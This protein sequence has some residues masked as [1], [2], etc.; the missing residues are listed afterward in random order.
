M[1]KAK[2]RTDKDTVTQDPLYRD[3]TRQLRELIT[4]GRFRA[5]QRFLSEREVQA[6]FQVS[7]PTANKA[8][9]SLMADGFVE[10]RRGVGTFVQPGV[11]DYDLRKLVSFTSK[12]SAAGL[13]PTTRVLQFRHLSGSDAVQAAEALMVAHDQPLLYMERLRLADDRPVILERRWV[14]ADLCPRLSAKDVA[15]SVYNLWTGR[16]GLEIAEARQTLRAVQLLRDDAEL[17]EVASRSAAM[18]CRCLG[19]LADGRALWWEHTLYRADAYEFHMRLGAAGAPPPVAG[20]FR[21]D[22][23]A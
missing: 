19:A 7:R 6:R 11:L 15:G 12:A 1:P 9:S 18:L 4:G 23:T 8:L 3:I 20:R 21:G 22:A 5:G 14:P 17:L 2:A 10:Y 16:Y 13:T